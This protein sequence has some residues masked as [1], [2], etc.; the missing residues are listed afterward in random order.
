MTD[1]ALR[2]SIVGAVVVVAVV[3]GL[4]LRS[5]RLAR[6]RRLRLPGLGPGVILFSGSGC[7]SC[8]RVRA[9]L[10]SLGVEHAEIGADDPRFPP[11]IDRVPTVAS[12]DGTGA[13][14]AISGVP[15]ARRLAALCAAGPADATGDP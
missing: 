5:G 3:T 8:D 2:L 11:G 1:V 7:A 13:G 9:G 4:V 6:R 14:V 12:L 10:R 15:S